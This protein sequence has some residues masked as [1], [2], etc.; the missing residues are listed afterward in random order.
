MFGLFKSP[1]FDDA[2]LGELQ[3]SGGLWRGSI[4]ALDG[5][6]VPLAI[7]GSRKEPDAQALRAAREVAGRFAGWRPIIE[8]ALF[9][10]YQPYAEALA[11]DD[12]PADGCPAT[13]LARASEVWPLVTLVYVAVTPLDDA[14]TTELGYM[15]SWDEEHTL[16]AR[17][18]GDSF[19]ELCGSVLPP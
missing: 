1:P 14:L 17:F 10:H 19:V 9:D 11:D 3:R 18:Q 6:R 2:Q 13:P 4:G 7:S 16:G 15:T 12:S 5:T 8:K